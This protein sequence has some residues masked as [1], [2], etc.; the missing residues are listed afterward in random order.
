MTF[1][2]AD[3]LNAN[4]QDVLRE[5]YEIAEQ[6]QF[7]Q[8]RK[9][10][11]ADRVY[12]EVFS[13]LRTSGRT[14]DV[15]EKE[16]VLWKS[17]FDTMGERAG[18]D[19]YSLFKKQNIN[20][21]QE[22]P[23]AL[24]NKS[25]TEM[26]LMIEK[27]KSFKGLSQ[28]KLFGSSLI[29][30]INGLGGV[31]AND[32]NAS[33]LEALGIE[34][35]HKEKKFRK[36]VLNENGR[37]LD[38]VALSA[39]E[40]GYFPEFT[41]RPSINDL[42]DKIELELKVQPQFAEG[43]G[44]LDLQAE[45]SQ[46]EDLD[47]FFNDLGID[48]NTQTN[49]EIK[50]IIANFE[51]GQRSEGKEFFQ[52][53]KDLIAQHN[54]SLD[55][56][57]NA[58]KLGGLPVP[59][60]AITKKDAPLANFGEITLLGDK[61]LIDPRADRT[62]KVFAADIY[63]PRY[64]S[65]NY[66]VDVKSLNDEMSSTLKG[67]DDVHAYF[68][69]NRIEDNGRRSLEESGAV[70][71][72]FLKEN[73]KRVPRKQKYN[74]GKISHHQTARAYIE[75]AKK[76]PEYQQF[77]DELFDNVIA[78]ERI[79]DGFTYSGNRKY[80]S[81][82]VENVV[83]VMKRGLNDGE[84]FNYGVGSIRAV[85][86][87]KF[88]SVDQIKKSKDKLVTEEEFTN[89][90]EEVDGEFMKLA[91]R[92]Q[93]KLKFES[94]S[95]SYLDTF[96]EHLKEA[97]EVGVP[98]VLNQYYEG[99][100]QSDVNEVAGFLK[101]LE[102]FP[103]E[104]FEAKLQRAVGIGEFE[105]AVVPRGKR[106]NEAVNIL[107]QSGVK[108]IRRYTEG[109]AE[110]RTQAV[111]KFEKLFFQKNDKKRG[112]FSFNEQGEKVIKLFES[113]DLSTILHE[114][115]HFFFEV[116]GE[117]SQAENATQDIKDD[118]AQILKFLEVDSA[119][120]IGT[121]QHE[122]FARAFEAYAFEGKAPSVEL[123]SAF[124]RFKQWLVS[125]YRNIQKLDV[126]LNDDIRGVFDRMLAT[127]EQ[128]KTSEELSAYFPVLK[129]KETGGMTQAEYESYL[130]SAE[131]ATTSAENDLLKKAMNE[132][133]RERLQWWKDEKAKTKEGVTQEVMQQPT[134]Q[135]LHFLQKG[136]FFEGGTPNALKGLKLDTTTLQ[137]LYGKE[138][139]KLL[140][141]S[142]PPIYKK[143]GAH[144]DAI[145]EVFGFD[146][147]DAL[148]KALWNAQNINQLIE[149]KTQQN[150]KERHGDILN[151][152]SIEEE[153]VKSIRTEDR[154]TFLATELKALSKRGNKEIASPKEVAK[155]AAQRFISETEV[156]DLQLGKYA[157][158]EVRAAKNA[159]QA[160]ADGDFNR[161][162]DE[163]RK[164]LFNHYL[165]IEAR[166][167]QE[168]V[169]KIQKYMTKFNKKSIRE[170][171]GK[172]RGNYL[173]QIDSLLER[174]DFRRSV[175]IKSAL[176]RESLSKWIDKQR[177][178]GN[179]VVISDKLE[180]EAFRKSFKLMTT[181]E[182]FGLEDTVRNIE[183]LARTK[184]KLL[185]SKDKR[186]FNE[187]VGDIVSTI[188]E[189]NKLKAIAP[190]YAPTYGSKIKKG[191]GSFFAKH[192]KMEF[193]FEQLDG[194]KNLGTTWTAL[195]KP[196][197]DAEVAEQ[198]LMTQVTK[199]LNNAF[200]QHS[201]RLERAKWYIDKVHVDGVSQSFNKAS[202][203]S[204]ALNWGNEGNR[205]AIR[206]GNGWSDAQVREILDNLEKKDWVLVQEIWDTI[207]SLWPQAKEVHKDV[208]GVAPPKVE[209]VPVETK[210]GTFK[211]GYYPLKYD[212]EFS[213]FAFKRE[214]AESTQGLFGSNWIRPQT[215]QG[216]LQERVGS[217]GQR[218]KLDLSVMTEHLSNTI[219]DVTHRKA[220]M[221][222]DRITRSPRVRDVIERAAGK[223]MYRQIRPWLQTI[224]NDRR[225]PVGAFEGILGRLRVGATVVNM[226][227][228]VTTAIV[229]PLG[230]LQ[231]VDLLGEKY[232]WVGLKKFYGSPAK[233]REG[234][235]FVM[236]RSGMM[237]NRQKTFDRDVRDTLKKTTLKGTSAEIQQSFF[238]FTGLMD[239][240]VA[241][242][243]WLGAYEKSMNGDVDGTTAGNEA[244]AIDF[245][246]K[247]V[248]MSQSAGGAKDLADIQT[249]AEYHRI[250]TMFYSYFNVLY[251]LL[252][253]RGQLTN[254]KKDI[255]RLAA[256]MMYLWFAPA[257]LSELVA[258]R[259]PEDEDEWAEWAATNAITY[260]F[261]T[262]VGVRDGVNAMFTKYGYDAS[263]AFDGAAETFKTFA[264]AGKVFNDDDFKRSD[265]KSAVLAASYWGQL[266]GR[267]VWITSEYLYD[268]ATGEEDEF[269]FRDL[270][271]TRK[272]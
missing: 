127:D 88:R 143:G 266:P 13:Q 223:E 42:I 139:F 121:E 105:A 79:F 34:D 50:E 104:Y 201:N 212:S 252:R 99:F 242:P 49:D 202:L 110:S 53:E 197:A 48:P 103:T 181:E 211:G 112:S 30:Y 154:A 80:L 236:E 204:L 83:R 200:K 195:F 66:E 169:D 22:L 58:Q 102:D 64:P 260:P 90:K 108:D 203:I 159:Q 51:E 147:G 207:D 137:Q 265:A 172:A 126:E 39:W 75:A 184:N 168:R 226:G 3:Q 190:D 98:K 176:K 192:T 9:A 96:S 46:I 73:G 188:E 4:I 109:D 117:L 155:K 186:E 182:L 187:V 151:D 157:A 86:T 27:Y 45:A 165:F 258:G 16:A 218:V 206:E 222:V 62:N 44:D 114:S 55:N 180:N 231:S 153:A 160:V 6:E 214:Q 138:V 271:F 18:T 57:R 220:L 136:E 191:V 131:R 270:V 196:L 178:E 251:N 167:A 17:F 164:Q 87:K 246:D 28:N 113:A 254:S 173:E 38:D 133:K 194:H 89:L 269:S 249:G 250:Y 40:A 267:Q 91:D 146:S 122:K 253:R 61:N 148:V 29:E 227:W 156:K 82:N 129:D 163:K 71:L 245:A 41:D 94:N 24:Q 158:A 255:P 213:F 59:S 85:F 21:T 95:F 100:D 150:M 243:T 244:Q 263:P 234:V 63:S 78:R 141:K 257:I 15:A 177:E 261:Q 128:I 107:K 7:D 37:A 161:A 68:D 237:Q 199:K 174:F 76:I 5:Q 115:G 149:E 124:R 209:G 175:S 171:L 232:G 183:H 111:G 36:R 93:E 25:V 135:A 259:G 198:A 19:A 142:V 11:P 134:Y 52:D 225:E 132:I 77:V 47:R 229:Q 145:A 74:D 72:K 193:L 210:H 125:I 35:W 1:T 219:H 20:I 221:D 166:K 228:K 65:I 101:K 170:R 235:N 32:V 256:S 10:A 268:Y 230:Y 31:S 240:S 217:A 120:Q 67:L 12:D 123:E 238:Y 14:I 130:K 92:M 23:P 70:A 2:E 144:P 140:P 116:M 118:Y 119:D 179:D 185:D 69:V 224:A 216:H 215:K 264:A 26:D 43:Q 241:V 248:R 189:N 33:D 60:L 84:G 8:R 272:K 233:M 152:G 81:H 262:I 208:T 54:L 106:Y 97:A 239:M 205:Q 162:I 247:T 56:L